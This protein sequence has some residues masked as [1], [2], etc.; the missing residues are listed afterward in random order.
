MEMEISTEKVKELRGECLEG[1]GGEEA[2]VKSGVSKGEDSIQLNSITTSQSKMQ[3]KTES[4]PDDWQ[5]QSGTTVQLPSAGSPLSN[6]NTVP[7]AHEEPKLQ[8]GEWL[9]QL[10]TLRSRAALQ[11]SRAAAFLEEME[12]ERIFRPDGVDEKLTAWISRMDEQIRERR[13]LKLEMD[14]HEENYWELDE[15]VKEKI[16]QTEGNFDRNRVNELHSESEFSR[17]SSIQSTRTLEA[18]TQRSAQCPI[19]LIYI[20]ISAKDQPMFCL[21]EWDTQF[22]IFRSR[23]VSLSSRWH[24]LDEEINLHRPQNRA[25]NQLRSW[26]VQM[27]EIMKERHALR[28]EIIFHA[29]K[30]R[31][32]L[33]GKD[34]QSSW[35]IEYE[36]GL[37]R[38]LDGLEGMLNIYGEEDLQH[39]EE[40]EI[41]IRPEEDAEFAV[42]ITQFPL[43]PQGFPS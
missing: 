16:S 30:V 10:D 19:P 17:E 15:V 31:Q 35:R 24:A 5:V 20:T 13:E 42:S 34:C 6:A 22:D 43:P 38:R 28:D 9:C 1:K 41:N 11:S 7:S 23:A 14:A 26:I 3:R 21:K 36:E 29:G 33:M 37:S 32:R 27:G 18:Y 40:A 8:A 4:R 12:R 39:L 25:A 2:E